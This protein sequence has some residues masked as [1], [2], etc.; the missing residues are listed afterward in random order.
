MKAARK[1]LL[2]TADRFPPQRVD[3]RILWA[4]EM[5]QRGYQ[6]DWIMAS[7]EPL[8]KEAAQPFGSGEVLLG[9]TDTGHGLWHRLRK[10]CRAIRNEWRVFSRSRSHRYDFLLVKDKAIAAVFVL[11][12]ARLRGIPCFYWLSFPFPENSLYRYRQGVARYPLLY[13]MR[14]HAQF[15][16][17]YRILLPRMQHVFVQSE[18]MKQDLVSYGMDAGKMTAVPMGVDAQALQ[19]VPV[20]PVQRH[21][22]AYLGTLDRARG[23]DFLLRVLVKV[24][25]VIPD[26]QLVLVGSSENKADVDWLK[27]EAVRLGVDASVIFAGQLPQAGAW[28]LLRQAR[29]ALSPFE[30]SPVLA[31][32]S[33]T[34]LVEYLGLGLPAIANAHPE[35]SRVITESQAGLVVEWDEQAFADAAVTLLTMDDPQ[36]QAMSSRGQQWVM[37]YRSYAVIADQLDLRIRKLLD[38]H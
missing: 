11:L 37:Q 24:R 36:W 26:A 7:D 13:W 31:S 17:L 8:A 21:L 4:R 30:P 15:V 1:G 20:V 38:A 25:D 18:Q 2:V 29:V 19:D 35:Q 5:A 23:L 9:A 3:V 34:K 32:A 14:G 33:P 6:L 10:H 22:L 12:A 27:A 28:Q 16:L